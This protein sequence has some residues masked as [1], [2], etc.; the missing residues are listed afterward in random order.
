MD[1]AR[2]VGVLLA[3]ADR[4]GGAA[5]LQAILHKAGVESGRAVENPA[6]RVAWQAAER[7]VDTA[8]QLIQG[9]AL[10]IHCADEQGRSCLLLASSHGLARVVESLKHQ[11]PLCDDPG[12]PDTDWSFSQQHV[13]PARAWMMQTMYLDCAA[14][15]SCG[16]PGLCKFA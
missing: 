4:G 1:E 10:D 13:E 2:T 11:V 3:R 6:D 14:G 15:G 16:H 7:L 8:T 5:M 9:N 12:L